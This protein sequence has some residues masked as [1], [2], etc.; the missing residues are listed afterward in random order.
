MKR[1]Y[2]QFTSLSEYIT[3]SMIK[4]SN[5]N[6]NT[7]LNLNQKK[8]NFIFILPDESEENHGLFEDYLHNIL[9]YI[10]NIIW[11]YPIILSFFDDTMNTP[12]I[13]DAH[14]EFLAQKVSTYQI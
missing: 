9:L 13:R 5:T 10:G 8:E 14:I 11:S 4:N 2:N 7:N 12:N 1:T 3:S 6:L